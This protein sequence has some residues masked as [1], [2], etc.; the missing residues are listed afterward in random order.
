MKRRFLLFIAML[1][2]ALATFMGCFSNL[3][4][5]TKNNSFKYHKENIAVLST[6][7]DS[8]VA[9]KMLLGL[10]DSCAIANNTKL[11]V[12]DIIKHNDN[13]IELYAGLMVRFY[14]HEGEVL[15]YTF[16]TVYFDDTAIL[17]Y[18]SVQVNP[19]KI[20]T[21]TER[22]SLIYTQREYVVHTTIEITPASGFVLHNALGTSKVQLTFKN[23]SDTAI[24]SVD[25]LMT[26]Y[27]SGVSYEYKNAS[28]SMLDTLT[29]NNSI[30]KTVIIPEWNNY[31]TYKIVKVIVAFSDG[32][33]IAF[34]SFDCQFLDAPVD[35]APSPDNGSTD[36]S[37]NEEE[38]TVDK[39]TVRFVQGDGFPDVE[40]EVDKDGS[41]E[42]IPIPKEV[43]GYEIKWENFNSTKITS[44]L[45]ISAIKT[46]IVYFITYHKSEGQVSKS[47]FTI[48]DLPI[49]LQDIEHETDIFSGWYINENLDGDIVEVIDSIGNF[50]L[51][52]SYV[53][54]TKGLIFNKMNGGYS[55]AKYLGEESRI[56]VPSFY[57]G[58]PVISIGAS[59]FQN[60]A[61]SSIELPSTLLEVGNF[62]FYKCNNLIEIDIPDTVETI[63]VQAFY[64][65]DFLENVIIGNGVELIRFE[66]F[67]S[68]DSLKVVKLGASIK[69]MEHHA[70]YSSTNKIYIDN[71]E[72]W[73]NI[74]FEEES[75]PISLTDEF[76]VGDKLLTELKI[77]DSVVSINPYTF[78]SYNPLTKVVL[79]NNVVTIGASAFKKCSKITEV[80]FNE[81]LK[82]IEDYAFSECTEIE[83]LDFG[84]A[85]ES[86]GAEA[87][88][89][90]TNLTNVL[91]PKTLKFLGTKAFGLHYL[92]RKIDFT[93]TI[94]DWCNISFG[95]LCFPNFKNYT[96]T[97][98][99]KLLTE[100]TIPNTLD[101]IHAFTFE[102]WYWLE[103]IKI[104]NT[105]KVIG[106]DA[107]MNCENLQK[108]EFEQKSNL[109]AIKTWAFHSCKSLSA[110]LLPSTVRS[111][112][113]NAFEN[114][115]NLKIY[116]ESSDKFEGWDEKPNCPIYYYSELPPAKTGNYW[117]Y[118][119]NGEIVIWG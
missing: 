23:K 15:L 4:N 63:G 96:L 57:K 43:E 87:F 16:E 84:N 119:S 118:D 42:N 74:S 73:F 58:L 33:A 34:D 11:V 86:I 48:Q 75:N 101:E 104:P 100:L 50:D 53:K 55:I 52:A 113:H 61:I 82:E 13:C 35:E 97:F 117:H 60:S 77:P 46:P 2:F 110:I 109:T 12:E 85:L 44:N 92:E 32:T 106:D 105:V 90:N 31:D 111:I 45:V 51:Y 8:V 66:A 68:C 107:F 78:Y 25:V 71:L 27:I 38:E 28:Y 102:N 91:L 88:Y 7:A 89:Y 69:K 67:R 29:I 39:Y 114:C 81:K 59:S 76:Y 21:E 19:V 54:G 41:I 94:E 79:G 3:D 108:I 10:E 36:T 20:L 47:T 80:I 5:S 93:G 18:D 98:N 26:P 72:A 56:I 1:I 112:E 9:E 62:A 95:G 24:S 83:K 22:N 103:T 17:L 99:S 116:F 64:Q 70:F 6:V 65:C 14:I 49:T 37:D 115:A 40:I 30:T